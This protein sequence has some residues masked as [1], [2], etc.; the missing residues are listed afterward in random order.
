M[1]QKVVLGCVPAYNPDTDDWSAYAEQLDLFFLVDEI[2]MRKNSCSLTVLGT[3]A[4]VG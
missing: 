2:K 4:T 1:A 3:K